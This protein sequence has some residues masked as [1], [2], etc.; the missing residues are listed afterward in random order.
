MRE[1]VMATSLAERP[2]LC[3]DL[4]MEYDLAKIIRLGRRRKDVEAELKREVVAARAAK[5]PEETIAA[6]A[7]VSRQTVRN[8]VRKAKEEQVGDSSAK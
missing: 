2:D 8:W 5:V 4:D 1:R 6:S 3:N 7:Q